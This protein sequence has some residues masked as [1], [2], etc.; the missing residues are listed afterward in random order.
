MIDLQSPAYGIGAQGGIVYFRTE[1]P[2]GGYAWFMGGTHSDVQNDPGSGGV[3]QMRLDG[4]GNLFVRGTVNPGGAD[5][6]EMLPATAGLEPGD[7]LAVAPDG[8]LGKSSEPYQTSVAGVFSTKPGF[9]G[10]AGD[11]EDLAG[12]VPLALVGIVPVKASAENGP[13]RPGD[14][15]VASAT[16][17]HA[18]RCTKQAAV[19][20]VIGKALSALDDGTGVVRMLVLLQ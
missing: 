15:L 20:T 13:I 1:P 12:K 5:F 3:R 16:P 17:G 19:G 8:S 11:G 14:R 6:A 2:G 4:A 9:L 18:M 7:V 10:G